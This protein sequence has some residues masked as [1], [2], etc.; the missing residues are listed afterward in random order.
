MPVVVVPRTKDAGLT[1]MDGPTMTGLTVP[2]TATLWVTATTPLTL[3]LVMLPAIFPGVAVALMRAV[4]VVAATVPLVGVKVSVD[5]KLV[6]SC[7]SS[8]PVGAVMVIGAPKLLPD[9]EYV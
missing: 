8:T 1:L 3:L 9:T 2:V 6:P 5:E 4:M 7:E